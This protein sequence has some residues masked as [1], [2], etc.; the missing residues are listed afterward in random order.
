MSGPA[1]LDKR[2]PE[3]D[4]RHE[5]VVGP[6][7]VAEISILGVCVPMRIGM[8]IPDVGGV[9]THPPPVPLRDEAEI[10]R[11]RIAVEDLPGDDLAHL[12]APLEVGAD[13]A[14]VPAA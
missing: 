1:P 8:L 10:R 6:E 4:L 2:L 12:R 5:P 11:P 14:V 13:H 7:A 9:R 3:S